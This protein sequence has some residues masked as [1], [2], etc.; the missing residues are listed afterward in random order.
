MKYAFGRL[1]NSSSKGI[2]KPIFVLHN[3]RNGVLQEFVF[4]ASE[5]KKLFHIV[6]NVI[7]QEERFCFFFFFRIRKR[8]NMNALITFKVL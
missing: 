2:K 1:L 3:N 5:A 7:K 4:S 6:K 8:D